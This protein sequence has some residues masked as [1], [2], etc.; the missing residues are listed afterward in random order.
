MYQNF[1]R[2]YGKGVIFQG[3]SAR[4]I[5]HTVL[6]QGDPVKV[7]DKVPDKVPQNEFDHATGMER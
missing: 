3:V 5:S 4:S 7:D 2:S 1:T 6:T